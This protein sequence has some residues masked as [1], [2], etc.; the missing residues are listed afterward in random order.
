MRKQ[1]IISI[2]AHK[3]FTLIEL[4]IVMAVITLLL[5]AA[6]SSMSNSRY[7]AAFFTA[8]EKVSSFLRQAR[9]YAV[10]GKSVT[11]YTDFDGDGDSSDQVTP[12]GF[13]V[14]NGTDGRLVLFADMHVNKTTG[15]P[16]EKSFQDPGAGK[17]GQYFAGSDIVLDE[18]TPDTTLVGLRQLGPG[19]A[20][21]LPE[22]S[23][24]SVMYSPIFA[25]TTF[26]GS[27]PS[28]QTYWNVQIYSK[29]ISSMSHCLWI[30]PIAGTP[31]PR[32]CP[33]VP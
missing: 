14:G 30:H 17:I 21:V 19:S 7:T 12:V 16:L 3:G 8:E 22:L 15:I 11:D 5:A 9:T 28:G 29:I 27:L 2:S 6:M 20:V 24:K 23:I 4:L 1:K 25:D 26:D 13:G 31:E 32:P 10:T 33:A 18:Y